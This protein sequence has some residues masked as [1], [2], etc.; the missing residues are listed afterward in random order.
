MM[1]GGDGS[2]GPGMDFGARGGPSPPPPG[3]ITPE[4]AIS[5]TT[6]LAFCLTTGPT[7]AVTAPAVPVTACF[8]EIVNDAIVT[9]PMVAPVPPLSAPQPPFAALPPAPPT[10]QLVSLRRRGRSQASLEAEGAAGRTGGGATGGAGGSVAGGGGSATEGGRGAVKDA[11]GIFF[12]SSLVPTE[13]FL[14][15]DESIVMALRKP[16]AGELHICHLP[17]GIFGLV[18]AFPGVDCT[19]RVIVFPSILT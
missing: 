3:A 1:F 9:A 16:R 4:G 15:L 8:A 13:T 10:V 2:C 12:L 11:V 7:P 17:P 18:P 14:V 5:L 19:T 6:L